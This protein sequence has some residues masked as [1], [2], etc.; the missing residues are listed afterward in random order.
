MGSFV[1]FTGSAALIDLLQA[2]PR[3]LLKTN[4]RSGMHRV[5]AG[6]VCCFR[7]RG[8]WWTRLSIDTEHMGRPIESLE[9]QHDE[10]HKPLQAAARPPARVQPSKSVVVAGFG[11]VCMQAGQHSSK[12]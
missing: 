2:T 5:P 9:V 10:R 7:R 4:S 3:H 12:S 11:H 1:W 6:G 8:L